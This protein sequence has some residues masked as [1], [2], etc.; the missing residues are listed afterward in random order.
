MK[1]ITHPNIKGGMIVKKLIS[2]LLAVLLILSLSAC[3]WGDSPTSVQTATPSTQP[4]ETTQTTAPTEVTSPD[5]APAITPLLYEVTNEQGHKIWL[6]GS[7]HIGR[8]EFYPLPPYVTQAF[9]QADGLA[10]EFDLVAFE[11]DLAAQV[12]ALQAMIYTDGTTIRDHLSPELYAAAV[13]ILEEAGV[14]N[15]MLDYYIPAMWATT[16]E[17]LSYELN[18]SQA[19]LGVDRQL[20][21]AAYEM[22]KPVLSI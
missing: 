19:A 16:I 17:S 15:A 21:N 6:F 1:H 12:E 22:D 9:A 11:K 13:A 2:L 3:Q 18:E 4:P 5:E 7:I 20:I 8:P 10:V 14:Y